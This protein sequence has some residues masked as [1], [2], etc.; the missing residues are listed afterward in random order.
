VSV[1][2]Y[3]DFKNAFNAV[4]HRAIFLSLEAYG[5]PCPDVDL[6]RR[7]YSGTW[8]SVGNSFGET[9][10]CYLSRGVKQGDPPSPDIFDST[11]NPAHKMIRDSGRGCS[12]PVLS[13]PSGASGFVDD[14]SLHTDGPDAIPAMREMV[15]RTS[16]FCRWVGI[17]VNMTKSC[18]SAIDFNTGR[19]VSTDSITLDGCPFPAIPPHCA[20]KHLGVYITLTGDFRAEK[21]HVLEEMKLRLKAL[22]EEKVLSPSQ[23]EL[24]INI[25]VVSVFRYSAGLVPWTLSE[26]DKITQMWTRGYKRAWRLPPSLDSSVMLLSLQDRGR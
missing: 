9:A 21:D 5:F 11:I 25:G 13:Q 14:T 3:L 19:Q 23:T 26:I 12:L 10:A 17:A 18:I 7:L 2:L 6:F 24:V 8:Y 20:H 15:E 22:Q 4:N 16:R 1:V